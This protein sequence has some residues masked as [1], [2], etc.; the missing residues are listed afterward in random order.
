VANLRTVHDLVTAPVPMVESQFG[1]TGARLQQELRGV[2]VYPLTLRRKP[3]QSVMSS[4]S[5]ARTTT[6]LAV[7]Q[8]AL[9]YHVRQAVA[10]VR[11]QRQRVSV[12]Q[13]TLRPSRHGAF[14]LR[15]GSLEQT[16]ELASNDTLTVLE[17]AQVLL[18]TLWQAGVPYQKVGVCLRGLTGTTFAQPSLFTPTGTAA[19]ARH[20]R[21]WQ[22]VDAVNQRWG[23]EQLRL[24]SR[25]Q[26]K[27]WQAKRNQLSPAYTTRWSDIPLVQA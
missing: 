9:A 13:V 6:N 10:D 4:R 26:E 14:A 7:V 1:V 23:K 15:G 16:L 24:G 11:A 12:V 17:A 19:T 20:A 25:G 2:S 21:L 3:Q 27:Q 8:D 22:T 5:F 18:T